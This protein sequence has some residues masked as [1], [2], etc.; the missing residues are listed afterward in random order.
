MLRSHLTFEEALAQEG[1]PIMTRQ[2]LKL[3]REQ[4]VKALDAAPALQ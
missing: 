1:I 2:R 3:I 4:I